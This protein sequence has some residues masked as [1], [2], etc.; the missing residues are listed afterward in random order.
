MQITLSDM[1]KDLHGQ[2]SLRK[3]KRKLRKLWQVTWD[4]KCKTADNWLDKSIRRMTHR[5]SPDRLETKVRKCEVT[6]QALW[7]LVKSLMKRDELEAQ[8]TVHGPLRIT[9]FERK[10]NQCTCGLFRKPVHIS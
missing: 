3:H 2:E 6:P 8:T 4:S 9:S 10:K 5:K 1:N 7:P